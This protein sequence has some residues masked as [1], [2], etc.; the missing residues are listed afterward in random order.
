MPSGQFAGNSTYGEAYLDGGRAERNPQIRPANNLN[1]SDNARFE[2][3][4][5]YNADY[6]PEVQGR[7]YFNRQ[8]DLVDRT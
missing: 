4:S 1:V 5:S 3:G 7:R 8:S 6:D 2:G